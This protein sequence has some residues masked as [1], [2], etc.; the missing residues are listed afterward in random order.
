MKKK[1]ALFLTGTILLLIVAAGLCIWKRQGIRNTFYKI[2]TGS[3]PFQIKEK[4]Q[5]TAHGYYKQAVKAKTE[6]NEVAPIAERDDAAEKFETTV[7]VEQTLVADSYEID[8]QIE[9]ELDNGYTWDD[10]IV[11]LNP[12]KISPLTGLIL[13]ETPKEEQVRITVKGKTEAADIV[14][15][16]EPCSRH[17]VPVVGLYPGEENTVVLELIDGQGNVRKSRELKI[18][19]EDLPENLRDSVKTIEN[20][21]KSAFGLTA[22]YGQK[23]KMPF[24]YDVNGDIRWYFERQAANYGMYQLSDD[25]IIF[26][27]RTGYVPCQQKPQSTN[28]YEMDCLGRAYRVYYLPA[29]NH[30]EVIEKEPGGNLLALTSSLKSCYEEKIVEIDRQTGKIVNELE[31]GDIFGQTYVDKPDWAHI[32]TVS[33]QP[34]GDTIIISAR[35]LN[36]VMKIN[37]STHK[38]EWIL[39]DPRFWKGTKFEKYVLQ[40]EED[41]VY[42]FEQH[43]AYQLE[44]DLDGDPQ[45]VELSLF[46]NHYNKDRKVDYYDGNEA[47]YV[48]V[49]SINEEAA[50]VKQIKRLAVKYSSITSAAIYDSESNHI[51]G[52]CGKVVNDAG[53]KSGM[54]YEFDYETGEVLNQYYISRD[55][56]RSTE[57]KLNF[58]DMSQKMEEEENYILGSLRPAVKISKKVKTPAEML[59]EGE[60]SFKLIGSV[61]YAGA[62]DHHISQVI[63]KGK[64]HTYVYDSTD[65][66]LHNK[67][68]L[69][70]YADTPIPLSQMEA[71]D[72]EIY[73]VYKDVYYRTGHQIAVKEK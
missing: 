73:C 50:T 10:P 63:F 1:K 17:R 37:W 20:S 39:C 51:F 70:Y 6:L 30:H 60:A 11:I 31:L 68:Y 71:D 40:P 49:Y 14:A 16:L 46:D 4:E 43:T 3:V 24:A 38:L 26:Q 28:L 18:R 9:A 47:S 15:E 34:E 62:M 35:N 72:Y 33:Y 58:Q 56:Y 36:S 32:N 65:I 45:T 54:N 57:L 61:L 42:H 69:G 48:V 55:F 59:E 21:G 5:M 53:E 12:Y 8:R 29:G 23:C 19:A 64:N 44:T 27:D 25:R 2:T 52:M 13:F 66:R 67:V 41:F 22:V 7:P